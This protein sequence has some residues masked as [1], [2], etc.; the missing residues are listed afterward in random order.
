[1]LAL[2]RADLWIALSNWWALFTEAVYDA[3]HGGIGFF[4]FAVMPLALIVWLALTQLLFRLKPKT[5]YSLP[6]VFLGAYALFWL[7]LVLAEQCGAWNPVERPYVMLSITVRWPGL[8][9]LVMRGFKCT[10]L[11]A[12]GFATC[13]ILIELLT[14]FVLMFD[15]AS[16]FAD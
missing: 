2:V 15:W 13:M 16:Y 12:W 1:M 4:A 9:L 11:R 3:W 14:Y 5:I 8:A 10:W 7:Q 6:G